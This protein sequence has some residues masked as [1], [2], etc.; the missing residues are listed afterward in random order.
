MR[1]ALL[2][3]ARAAAA[4]SFAGL[5]LRAA[6]D[7]PARPT[8]PEIW[9]K[10]GAY[11]P[12]FNAPIDNMWVVDA[13]WPRVAARVRVAGFPPG[14]IERAKDVELQAAFVGMKQRG[15]ALG[16]GT[17]LLTRSD[18]CRAHNEAMASPGE[19]E[20][21]LL[22]IRRDG[23][24]LRYI[25]MDEPYYFG[26]RDASGCHQSAAELAAEVA[27][28]VATARRIFPSV[29]IGDIEV[30]GSSRPWIEELAAW[31]DTYRRTTGEK[32]A[33]MQ[34]DVQWSDLAMRNLRPLATAMRDRGIP[35]SI[36]YNANVAAT[37][38]A[39]WETS[40][41]GHIAQIETALAIHPDIAAFDSWMKNPTHRLPETAPRTLTNLALR[42][43]SRSASALAL[44]RR[45]NVVT[46]RLTGAE[47]RPVVGASVTVTAVDVGAR[48]APTLRTLTGAV[49]AN[50]VGALVGI[51]VDTDGACVC[52]GKTSA[53]IGAIRYQETGTG[54]QQT[55]PPFGP[56]TK[57]PPSGLRT[58][59]LVPG[60]G[61]S[62][63]LK[64]IPVTAGAAYTFEAPIAAT[65][66]AEN[67]GYATAIFVDASGKGIS[68]T[69]LWFGPSR[70][71][72]GA[73]RTDADGRFSLDLP[74]AI[75]AARPELRAT[76]A[77]DAALRGA[78]AIVE[79]TPGDR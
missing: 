32:L 35:I 1:T 20:Q 37:T 51:R 47:G 36:I 61:F 5:A 52:D 21:M 56:S 43:V 3:A 67:A 68:R 65:A 70:R 7:P 30:V 73:A 33:F 40:A 48:M 79:P 24:D 26:H 46:G 9:I 58:L 71:D 15:I 8:S 38:D 13:P 4:L 10:S 53:V 42:Y 14:N 75:A 6:A 60:Q 69:F 66:S 22:K 19:L 59:E 27:Q 57:A 77:G 76:F 54:R 23:G 39:S 78:L 25:A 50:A 16:L 29:Q 63:N 64:Q 74:G 49:P 28:S 12:G 55:I 72:L 45:G 2:F 34:S 17:G 62:P 18:R 31:A 44:T 41:E 11:I